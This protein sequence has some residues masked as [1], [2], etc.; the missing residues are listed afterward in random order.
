MTETAGEFLRCPQC[1]TVFRAPGPVERMP[2]VRCGRCGEAFDP[3]VHRVEAGPGPN[4]AARPRAAAA[5]AAAAAAHVALPRRRGRPAQA[6][7]PTP[8]RR[9]RRLPAA[10]GVLAFAL[11]LALGVQGIGLARGW[12]AAQG[13]ELPV[14]GWPCAGAACGTAGA[15]PD[16]GL[17]GASVISHAQFT[18][19]LVARAELHNTGAATAPLPRIELRFTDA[20]GALVAGRAFTPLEYQRGRERRAGLGAGERVQV[21]L[22]LLDP[23][24]QAV[25]YQFRVLP[26]QAP[27]SPT[28]EG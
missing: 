21:R 2:A 17:S 1:S 24:P 22:H 14:P 20:E 28:T 12:L 5:G 25:H 23:G 27:R 18:D 11:A 13:L 8:R 9:A 10:A 15:A 6:L 4:L 7:P 16:I 3:R 26:A 19:A